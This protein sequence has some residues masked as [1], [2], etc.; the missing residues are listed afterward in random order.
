[1]GAIQRDALLA[2]LI[3]SITIHLHYR[4]GRVTIMSIG[5]ADMVGT[6]SPLPQPLLVYPLGGFRGEAAVE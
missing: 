3:Q 6:S 5:Q 1:M 4:I 2:Q